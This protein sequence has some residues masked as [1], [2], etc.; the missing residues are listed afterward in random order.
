MLKVT[1]KCR[2]IE[3]KRDKKILVFFFF[4]KQKTAYEIYQCD[5]SSDV[6]S[7]DL[8]ITYN[9]AYPKNTARELRASNYTAVV[10]ERITDFRIAN[11]TAWQK[12]GPR[13]YPEIGRASCRERV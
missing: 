8:V 2:S 11:P 6:C 10:N 1:R 3:K 5:W 7:S 4:F 13:K 12:T 9:T